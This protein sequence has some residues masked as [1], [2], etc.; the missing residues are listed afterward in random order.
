MHKDPAL[1]FQRLGEIA[2]RLAELSRSWKET[3]APLETEMLL[4]TGALY[5]RKLQEH[6]CINDRFRLS[7]KTIK[8]DDGSHSSMEDIANRLIH[9]LLIESGTPDRITFRSDRGTELHL[10]LAAFAQHFREYA[11]K[12]R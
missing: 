7:G 5:L 10:S 12:A 9:S 8:M 11:G 4:V 6:G 2:D 3:T 1:Y